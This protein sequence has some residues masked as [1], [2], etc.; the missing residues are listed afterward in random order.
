MPTFGFIRDLRVCREVMKTG[1]SSTIQ[2]GEKYFREAS[3]RVGSN[4]KL[5]TLFHSGGAIHSRFSGERVPSEILQ[6]IEFRGIAPAMIM[7][8]NFGGGTQSYCSQNNDLLMNFHWLS[9]R[10][11]YDLSLKNGYLTKLDAHPNAPLTN[12]HSFMSPTFKPIIQ[13]ELKRFTNQYDCR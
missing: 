5:L 10:Q 7:P 6:K 2:H 3:D 11:H 9:D 4:G 13:Y 12:D 1:M 8:R